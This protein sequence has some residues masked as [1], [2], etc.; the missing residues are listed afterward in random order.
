MIRHLKPRAEGGRWSGDALTYNPDGGVELKP[1]FIRNMR[2]A[3]GQDTKIPERDEVRG[4]TFCLQWFG[5][6]IEVGV[7]RVR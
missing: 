6:M 2:I 5:L 7:G 1:G 3:F 4:W